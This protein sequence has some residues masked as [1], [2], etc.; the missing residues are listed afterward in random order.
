M[1]GQFASGRRMYVA[2]RADA[3]SQIP[4]L[5]A[6]TCSSAVWAVIGTL[7]HA[8]EGPLLGPKPVRPEPG[9]A[10]ISTPVLEDGSHGRKLG[11]ALALGKDTVV[12]SRPPDFSGMVAGGHVC[13]RLDGFATR[14]DEQS[15]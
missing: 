8:D 12:P 7:P 15:E 14:F 5:G 6:P 4:E 13:K 11:N 1:H 3:H 9:N 10:P 2:R